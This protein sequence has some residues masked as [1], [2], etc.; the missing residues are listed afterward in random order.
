MSFRTDLSWST[1]VF[2]GKVAPKMEAHGYRVYAA[3]SEA[4]DELCRALDIHAGIDFIAEKSGRM[5]GIAARCQRGKSWR[6]FT[7]RFE[8]DSGAKTEYAKRCDAI[9]HKF[10]YPRLTVQS[11]LDQSTGELIDAAFCRTD[12]LMAAV[13]EGEQSQFGGDICIRRTD[14]ASFVVVPW[15]WFT[16][17]GKWLLQITSKGGGK[18]V[19]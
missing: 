19:G 18:D 17:R 8:R 10:L 11:Y 7:V 4:S 2:L 5:S 15:A 16:S 9:E 13:K 14:N 12:D 3:E 1:Q 6:T